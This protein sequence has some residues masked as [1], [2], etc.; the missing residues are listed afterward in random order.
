MNHNLEIPQNY[1]RLMQTLH[2]GIGFAVIPL[3]FMIPVVAGVTAPSEGEYNTIKLLTQF[4]VV[5]FLATILASGFVNSRMMQRY[6][7]DLHSALKGDTDAAWSSWLEAYKN[8]HIV[9]LALREG[10]AMLGLVT[11]L[12]A[13]INGVLWEDPFFWVNYFS[14]TLFVL[15]L[16]LSFPT[17]TKIMG[18]AQV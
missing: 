5:V 17:A 14:T 18:A 6:N 12:L 3:T 8:A 1:L 7:S 10:P 16:V 13:S 9:S 2:L 11:L 15:Y 4:H